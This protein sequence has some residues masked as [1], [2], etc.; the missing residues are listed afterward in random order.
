MLAKLK[1]RL[2]GA[3]LFLKRLADECFLAFLSGAVTAFVA[4][5]GA[6]D[7]VALTGVAVA[8]GRAALGF[9]VAKVGKKNSPS[10]VK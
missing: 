9:L 1:L 10:L 6:M 3:G 5:G 8:G 4:T 2:F 7:K